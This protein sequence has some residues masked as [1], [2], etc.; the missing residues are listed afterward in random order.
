[1]NGLRYWNQ[2]SGERRRIGR[3]EGRKIVERT[4]INHLSV[5]GLLWTLLCIMP[6]N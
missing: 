1:M 5:H 2:G 6:V 4:D 3:G